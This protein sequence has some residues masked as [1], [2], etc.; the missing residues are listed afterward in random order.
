MSNKPEKKHTHTLPVNL[1]LFI[2]KN[3]A[4]SL[5][6]FIALSECRKKYSGVTG[7]KPEQVRFKDFCAISKYSQKNTC[8]GVSF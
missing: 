1:V 2:A 5:V 8:I 6:C 4:V 7:S 3:K